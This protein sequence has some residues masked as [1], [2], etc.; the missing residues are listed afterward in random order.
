MPPPV[1]KMW[2]EH[3]NGSRN[4]AY[5]LWTILMF[6]AWRQRWVRIVSPR[7]VLHVTS[8]LGIGGAEVFLTQVASALQARGVPQYVVCIGALDEYADE[9]RSRGVTVTVLGVK[10]M[11]RLPAGVIRL[12]RLIRELNPE[13]V[14][15]WMYHGNILAA[16]AHLLAGRRARRQLYWNLRASNVDATRYG[17]VVRISATLSRVPD[18]II[19]NSQ[20]GKEFHINQGF[21][22]RRLEVIG[23]GIDTQKFRPDAKLRAARRSELGI[24]PDAVVAIHAARVDPM[25]DHPALLA[26][27]AAIPQVYGLL[28]GA[29]TET[30]HVPANVRALGMRRD[31]EQLYAVADIVVSSSAFGEGFSNVVAEGMSAG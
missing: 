1:R 5:A 25:K 22:P 27:M 3:V 23:N 9:L 28:V 14:Q 2:S 6:E 4:W 20:A 12:A 30:L 18:L 31:M 11:A 17:R 8:G 16:L 10:G 29:G 19:A 24:S 21:R 26:A 7:V 15:G 13:V